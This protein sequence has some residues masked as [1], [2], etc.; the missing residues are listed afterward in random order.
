MFATDRHP[1]AGDFSTLLDL[2]TA[3][4][5]REDELGELRAALVRAVDDAGTDVWAGESGEAWRVEV[6]T[7][8]YAADRLSGWYSE[9]A[10]A[11]TVY[12]DAVDEIRRKAAPW[13][14]Q[15]DDAEL[16]LQRLSWDPE[17]TGMMQCFDPTT[18]DMVR[19]RVQA[20]AERAQDEAWSALSRLLD[21][22]RTADAALCEGLESGEST[23]W[24]AARNALARLGI[25][26]VNQ[27]TNERAAAGIVELANAVA[28]GNADA[29]QR[30]DLEAL[31]KTW[32][33]D[34][35]VL[36]DAFAELGGA[37]T[38]RLVDEAATGGQMD[39]AAALRSALSTASADWSTGE[40]ETFVG[41]LMNEYTAM[42]GGVAAIGYLFAD[43]ENAPLGV[44]LV[45]A[46]ATEADRIERLTPGPWSGGWSEMTLSGV[47]GLT[48]D[49]AQG[50]RVNDAAGR[51]LQTLGQYPDE[52]LDW[53]STE[54]GSAAHD[55]RI[56]YWFETRDWSRT[57][58]GFEGPAALWGGASRASGGPAHGWTDDGVS[59]RVAVVTTAVV[60]GLGD[61]QAL[62]GENVSTEGSQE[63]AHAVGVHLPAFVEYPLTGNFNLSVLERSRSQDIAILGSGVPVASPVVDDQE[64]K[65][66][67]G[68]MGGDSK[69]PSGALR[70]YVVQY[71]EAAMNAAFDPANPIDALGAIDRITTLGGSLGGA[72]AGNEAAVAVRYDDGVREVFGAGAT[73]A[74]AAPVPGGFIGGYALSASAGSVTTCLADRVA[75]RHSEALAQ[76]AV[77]KVEVETALRTSLATYVEKFEPESFGDSSG[78]V[79]RDIDNVVSDYFE[80]YDSAYLYAKGKG[81]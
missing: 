18:R 44:N 4:R 19:A 52:A 26:S 64:L 35:D 71:E 36:D 25:D 61:N 20:D 11:V 23:A 69:T 41:T 39:L 48:G 5:A 9:A 14:G 54:E 40:A 46:A 12:V 1:D 75:T 53:L 30:A 31:L 60:R 37:A 72:S 81:E 15:L 70:P 74:G 8:R 51:I 33:D 76:E 49:N 55:D 58:D 65:R 42:T 38:V 63:F 68:A 22:R 13:R 59:E 47:G 17:Y 21:D 24:N 66:I 78:G 28:S 27:L 56:T 34:D 43:V 29:Q 62:L 32:N 6:S 7:Q 50:A 80:A 16:T 10:S 45:V 79:E 3:L 67:L 77:D 2:R 57:G 73:A